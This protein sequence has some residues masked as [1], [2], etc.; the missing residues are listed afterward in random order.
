ML[1]IGKGYKTALIFGLD[2]QTE[3]YHAKFLKRVI[4][5]VLIIIKIKLLTSITSEII[6][7]NFKENMNKQISIIELNQL[8]KLKANID[9]R[10]FIAV[11]KYNG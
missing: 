8:A 4:K 1:L 2:F 7:Y 5:N 11:I 10:I 9:Q 6:Y 3:Y